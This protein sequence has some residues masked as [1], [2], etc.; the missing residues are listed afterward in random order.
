MPD[1]KLRWMEYQQ[2]RAKT[3][4]EVDSDIKRE[5]SNFEP[6]VPRFAQP[7][8]EYQRRCLEIQLA[9]EK[10]KQDDKDRYFEKYGT[11]RDYGLPRDENGKLMMPKRSPSPE[12][13]FG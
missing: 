10:K 11:M 8:T 2:A 13:R 3:Q 7:K 5:P 12:W 9:R 6:Q 4:S 1:P